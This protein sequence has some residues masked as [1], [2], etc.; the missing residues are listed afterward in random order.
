MFVADE[1]RHK[2]TSPLLVEMIRQVV[3][4]KFIALTNS[5]KDFPSQGVDN[6][7]ATD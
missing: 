5:G 7:C 4:P 3:Y 1:A 2:H 6:A